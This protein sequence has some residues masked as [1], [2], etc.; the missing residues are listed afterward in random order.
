MDAPDI[1]TW[2]EA[3][4]PPALVHV[5]ELRPSN[6][7]TVSVEGSLSEE[8]ASGKY[9]LRAIRDA[10]LTMGAQTA[11]A[12]RYKQLLEFTKSQEGTL[13]RIASFAPFVVDEYL[14]LPSIVE[15]R[16]RFDLSDDRTEMRTMRVQYIMDHP[17]RAV[18][19][20]PTWRDYLWREYPYPKPPH[21]ALL[22]KTAEEEDVW[23]AAV[24]EGW[25]SGLEQAQL[26]WENNLNQLVRDIRGRITYRILES[27]NIVQRP[28]MVGSTPTIT[29]SSDGRTLNAGDQVYSITVPVEFTPDADW[30][31][32]WR[33]VDM[34][35]PRFQLLERESMKKE[36]NFRILG[37]K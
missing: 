16:D 3:Q 33:A 17:P 26:S 8:M 2:I 32:L 4:N 35:Q 20:P 21:P 1:S 13:D 7:D 36:P 10:G 14:L 29:V 24:E 9:R 31:P 27:R 19:Q 22:P 11:L 37:S 28:V 34:K 5:V 25:K 18:S 30:K 23:E 6:L 12:W 15:T